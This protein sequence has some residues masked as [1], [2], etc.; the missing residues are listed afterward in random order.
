[1]LDE[2]CARAMAWDRDKRYRPAGELLHD[3]ERY[4]ETTDSG[5]TPREVGL[6]V[7]DLFRD[8]RV[9]VNGVIESHLARIRGDAPREALPVLDVAAR[10]LTPSNER[11]ASPAQRSSAQAHRRRGDGR[12][13]QAARGPRPRDRRGAS[14]DGGNATVLYNIGQTHYQLQNYAAALV[15]LERY[16]AEAGTNAQH[17]P[18][19]EQT[20]EILRT[21]RQGPDLHQRPRLR[22][23]RRRRA[24]RED[25]AG[26]PV[27][28]Q[29]RPAQVHR[30]LPRQE[31]RH[32][33]RG[34]R[35]RRRGPGGAVGRRGGARGSEVSAAPS[36]I[37]QEC[38]VPQ[39]AMNVTRKTEMGPIEP[40]SP[41][42][43]CGCY[44]EANVVGGTVPERCKACAGPGD[45]P[46]ATP[47]CNE[48]FC[49]VR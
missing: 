30:G 41:P 44:F 7:S 46:S 47:A 34:G 12:G 38:L 25:P 20:L 37:H 26:G 43:H 9:R 27:D 14:P 13:R 48:G 22:D 15:M 1:L 10:G 24:R 49:E 39:C 35:R 11:D 42:Y 6:C 4:L 16:M 2:I 21:R 23:P 40:N 28:R 45:C 19:V 17:R 3:L 32:P 8:D 5:V 31:R 18:E 33:L 29:R 36:G